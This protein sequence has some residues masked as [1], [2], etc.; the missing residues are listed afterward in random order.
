MTQHRTARPRRTAVRLGALA[1]PLALLTACAGTAEPAATAAATAETTAGARTE[2]ATYTPRL[3]LTYD[4]GLVVLDATTLETVSTIEETGFL[5][6]NPA[7]DGRHVMV[8]AEGGFRLLDAGTWAEEHGDHDHY[9][10]ADPTLT[11]VTFPAETPGHVVV[12][13]DRTVLFDDGTGEVTVLDPHQLADGPDAAVRTYTT[14]AAHHGVAVL[15]EDD[16]LVVTD[17][18]EEERTGVRLLDADDAEVAATDQCPGVHGETVAADEVVTV[19]CQDGIVVIDGDTVTKIDAPTD[20]GR[21]GN[22]SGSEESTVV[23]G[24]YKSD[25][26]ADLERPTRVSLTDTAAGE[27]TLVDLPSSYTFRSLA[28]GADGEALVLGTDGQ[29]HVIDPD[30]AELVRSIPV[31]DEW[32]EPD[33]W[34]QPR[35][36][37]HVLDGTAYVTDPATDRVL[38]V[39]VESGEVWK[40]TTLDVTPNEITSAAG[41]HTH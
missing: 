2:A 3:V 38:A 10:T 36:A 9:W 5:R 30:T 34:Q 1:L 33:E 18:T 8:S 24:D 15:R 35:P 21:I 39:D 16:H 28:R 4:G 20:Y 12:H 26:D 31:I 37:I 23:L 25:P 6:V 41:R 7:G 19:G 29:I 27:I 40:E 14:P 13:G 32:T 17:G 22:Q 11:D